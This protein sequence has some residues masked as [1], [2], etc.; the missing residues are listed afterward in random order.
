MKPKD[1][2]RKLPKLKIY[3]L[4]WLFEESAVFRIVDIEKEAP[5]MFGIKVDLYQI[6]FLNKPTPVPSGVF[7]KAFRN[8]HI[9][10]GDVLR[11]LWRER[12]IKGR[13]GKKRWFE[14]IPVAIDEQGHPM[15]KSI[16]LEKV[17]PTLHA[18]ID[19]A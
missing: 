4:R 3:T 16:G 12:I 18:G 13:Q 6:E 10:R 8:Y 1:E 5:T 11:L 9:E 2:Q 15:V 7:S 19:V 17:L 14:P